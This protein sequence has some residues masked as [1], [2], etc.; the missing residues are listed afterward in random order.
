MS[1]TIA[2]LF[3]SLGCVQVYADEEKALVIT[4]IHDKDC[5]KEITTTISIEKAR[6]LALN[7]EKLTVALKDLNYAEALN[8]LDEMTADKIVPE[9]EIHQLIQS[10]CKDSHYE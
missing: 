10:H 1:I 2:V 7:L 6:G 4:Y 9:N 3:L 8:I 5:T